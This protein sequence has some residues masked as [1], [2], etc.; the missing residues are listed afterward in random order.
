V[1]AIDTRYWLLLRVKREEMS[2]RQRER[3]T[4]HV[5]TESLAESGYDNRALKVDDR[6][7][8]S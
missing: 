4:R 6:A 8:Q 7:A 2:V 3:G 1:S 5:R